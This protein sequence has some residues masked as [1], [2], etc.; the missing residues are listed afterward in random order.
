MPVI[1][2]DGP[3]VTEHS[4]VSVARRLTNQVKKIPQ[5]KVPLTFHL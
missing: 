2:V 4:I 3:D 5:A 1:M